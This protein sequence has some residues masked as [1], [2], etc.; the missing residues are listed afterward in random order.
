MSKSLCFEIIDYISLDLFR[1]PFT[2]ILLNNKILT[3]RN[4][5]D[6]EH[7]KLRSLVQ[8]GP[9]D[10]N[11]FSSIHE[12]PPA[13]SANYEKKCFICFEKPGQEKH[14]VVGYTY[15]I[16]NI[17]NKEQTFRGERSLRLVDKL[18]VFWWG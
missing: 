10:E 4:V 2:W 18:L 9:V 7:L 17:V 3:K 5:S 6:K 8:V 15:W 13:W 12:F 16:H 11:F 1:V 14:K